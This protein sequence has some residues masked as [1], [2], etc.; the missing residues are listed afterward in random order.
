MVVSGAAWPQPRV[1]YLHVPFCRHR[2]GYCNFSVVAGR[3]DLITRFLTAVDR[4]L[5]VL[6]KPAV[7]T[8]FIGGGTP[9]HLNLEQLDRLLITVNERFQFNSG[10]EW[11]IEANPEDITAEKL[12]RLVDHGVNRISLG[13]QSFNRDKL[14]LLERSH[15]GSSAA[16]TI[17]QVA[18][19]IANV[20]M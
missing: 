3:D 6:E 5:A 13:V 7:Q 20:S 4:E 17:E 11:S 16:R 1:A 14:R 10:Y 2:C 19:K 12:Q 15:S 8:V 18:A 9:T